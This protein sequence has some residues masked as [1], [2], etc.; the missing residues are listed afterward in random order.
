MTKKILYCDVDEK[1]TWRVSRKI[2]NA[3]VSGRPEVTVTER[4]DLA[5]KVVREK[6]PDLI[7]IGD[8][9]EDGNGCDLADNLR[10]QGY[11]GII[12]YAGKYP[13]TD[14]PRSREH[15]FNDFF[16]K[17]LLEQNDVDPL[18]DSVKRHLGYN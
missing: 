4:L 8:F 10:E 5:L 18:I 12:I 17:P 2:R 7:L 11:S 15:A 3:I 13:K 9:L 6:N 14:I 16:Q 1:T